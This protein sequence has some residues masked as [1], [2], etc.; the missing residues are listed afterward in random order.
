MEARESAAD[1]LQGSGELGRRELRSVAEGRAPAVRAQVA[2]GHDFVLR[3]D[4][5]QTMR[6]CLEVEARHAER[7]LVREEEL[8]DRAPP[9]PG[10]ARQVLL[11]DREDAPRGLVRMPHVEEAELA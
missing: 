1:A 5:V 8:L 11:G 4:P 9:I 3:R 6:L 7:A 2:E 10:H